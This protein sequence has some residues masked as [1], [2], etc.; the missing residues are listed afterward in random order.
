MYI[1]QQIFSVTAANGENRTNRAN[2]I[3]HIHT[4][5]NGKE[6]NY[7]NKNIIPGEQRFDGMNVE[8]RQIFCKIL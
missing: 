3:H 5:V 1:V 7:R 4:N 2:D 8:C 6:L